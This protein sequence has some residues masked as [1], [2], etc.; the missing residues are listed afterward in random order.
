MIR[1]TLGLAPA[2]DAELEML[3]ILTR[4]GKRRAGLRSASSDRLDTSSAPSPIFRLYG[5]C[6]NLCSRFQWLLVL[7]A[8]S[9]LSIRRT[10]D[11][12]VKGPVSL[13]QTRQALMKVLLRR[14]FS[15]SSA[16]QVPVLLI[17]ELI[18][19]S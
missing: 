7:A 9:D 13:E 1:A 14:H 19:L 8:K 16:A 11:S 17:S 3:D 10:A 6:S 18:R 15:F 4:G 12:P 2:T 5:K